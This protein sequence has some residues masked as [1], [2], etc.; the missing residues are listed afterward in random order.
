MIIRVLY[1]IYIIKQQ[2][3][4]SYFKNTLYFLMDDIIKILHICKK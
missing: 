3:Y 4:F 2:F 1:I